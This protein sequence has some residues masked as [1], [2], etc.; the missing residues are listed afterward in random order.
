MNNTDSL[1]CQGTPQSLDKVLNKSYIDCLQKHINLL[2]E[3][4]CKIKD[5]GVIAG[6]NI[7]IEQLEENINSLNK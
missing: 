1:N 6:I 4:R 2:K 7:A 3:K 5:K